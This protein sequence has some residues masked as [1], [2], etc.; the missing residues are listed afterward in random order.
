MA[1]GEAL[2][3]ISSETGL[4]QSDTQQGTS[5]PSQV[6]V[7]P[8]ESKTQSNSEQ[9]GTRYKY[10]VISFIRHAQSESNVNPRL[11]GGMG[12][13]L[14]PKGKNQAK[15]LGQ[16]WA[17]TRIDAIWSSDMERAKATA[18]AIVDFH[19]S[20]LELKQDSFLRE[21]N[22]G[23]EVAQHMQR[24]DFHGA[25][26]LRSGGYSPTSEDGRSYYPP[27]GES[28]D[29]VVY[30]GVLMLKLAILAHGRYLLSPP[31]ELLDKGP[32]NRQLA[33]QLPDGVPHIVFVSHNMF[34]VELYEALLSWEAA[35]HHYLWVDYYNTQWY[36]LCFLNR[37]VLLTHMSTGRVSSLAWETT[38]WRT[39]RDTIKRLSI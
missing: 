16:E 33:D 12:D 6:E 8:H 24:G 20:T 14:T 18:Q 13:K 11:D 26:K 15:E 23:P 9:K 22:H 1:D 36:W 39:H 25:Q 30:R 5:N 35:K 28:A 7:F 31:T 29:S 34:L 17:N 3:S 27:G 19:S 38:L 37:F 21:R 32:R 10:A 4:D 2:L